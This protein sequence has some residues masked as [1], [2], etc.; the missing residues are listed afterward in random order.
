VAVGPGPTA[1]RWNK[2]LRKSIW[3]KHVRPT[4]GRYSTSPSATSKR[5][6]VSRIGAR[7]MIVPLQ[8]R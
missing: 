8:D 4:L 6:I 7:W 1:S 3:R 5:G 2:I